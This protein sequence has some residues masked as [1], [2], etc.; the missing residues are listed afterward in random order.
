[1]PFFL[2]NNAQLKNLLT[3]SEGR[4]G[5]RIALTTYSTGKLRLGFPVTVVEWT[6]HEVS[7]IDRRFL[8]RRMMLG[9]NVDG[10]QREG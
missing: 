6:G 1:M 2:K 10:F 8:I 3:S 9:R 4:G 5:L 7:M